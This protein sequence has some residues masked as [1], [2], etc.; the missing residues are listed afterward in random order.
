MRSGHGPFWVSNSEAPP[1][2]DVMAESCTCTGLINLMRRKI[3]LEIPGLD[4]PDYEFPGGTWCWFNH[5]K[6]KGKL[7]NFNINMIYP[8]GTLL[9]RPYRNESE[10]GHMAVVYTDNPRNVL[11]AKLIHSYSKDGTPHPGR[12]GLYGVKIDAAVGMSHFWDP[13]GF[14]THACLPKDWLR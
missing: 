8:K 9:L 6:K 1:S 2:G 7:K 12:K 13:K 5:L 14:Y 4:R 10:Q 3:G 11:Y